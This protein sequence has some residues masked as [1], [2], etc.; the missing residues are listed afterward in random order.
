MRNILSWAYWM[1]LIHAC[2]CVCLGWW[3]AYVCL[4]THHCHNFQTCFTCVVERES[5]F[6]NIVDHLWCLTSETWYLQLCIITELSAGTQ[7]N[8]FCRLCMI[9][10]GDLVISIPERT[11]SAY[12]YIMVTCSKKLFLKK[13]TVDIYVCI[14]S[15]HSVSCYVIL[16]WF[17]RFCLKCFSLAVLLNLVPSC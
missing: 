12:C 7:H 13:Q 17:R 1:E 5:S 2:V 16:E 6:D 9:H 14:Y 8:W 4:E 3:S 11:S 15:Y 10:R